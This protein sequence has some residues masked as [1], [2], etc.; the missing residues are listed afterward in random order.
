MSDS[1]RDPTDV[2]DEVLAARLAVEP[3]DDVTRARLVRTAMAASEPG[4]QDATGGRPGSRSRLRWLAVAAAIV[5]LLAVGLTVVVRDDSGSGPSAARASKAADAPTRSGAQSELALGTTDQAFSGRSDVQVLGAL[6]DVGT[7]AKLRKAVANV[8]PPPEAPAAAV[9][10]VPDDAPLRSTISVGCDTAAAVQDLGRPIAVG[11]GTLRD[12][13]V[14]V[15][16][17]QRPNGTLVAV[18]I[19]SDCKTGKP[20]PL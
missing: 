2:R 16:V 17:V 12:Q 8:T 1:P 10:A 9:I 11:G 15:Y 7:K 5:A 20:V 19:S 6:G 18:T 13:P 14:T 4:A 3:L